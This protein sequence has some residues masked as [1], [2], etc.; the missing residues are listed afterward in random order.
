MLARLLRFRDLRRQPGDSVFQRPQF[1]AVWRRDRLIEA[2]GPGH[3]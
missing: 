2:A 1:L 3:F